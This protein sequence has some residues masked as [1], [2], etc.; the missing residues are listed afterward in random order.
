MRRLSG[1]VRSSPAL[2]VLLVIALLVPSGSVRGAQPVVDGIISPQEYAS[3]SVLADGLY[4]LSWTVSG[5]TV[6]FGIQ[7]T[8]TGWVALGL[9]PEQMMQGADMVFGWVSGGKA[10]VLDQY[11]T[12]TFGPHPDDTTLGGRMD[13][14]SSVG[15]EQQG[16]TT[17][18]YSRKRVTG[19]AYDKPVP[20]SG[21]LK[22]IW[23]FGNA[24]TISPH[25]RRGTAT[26]RVVSTQPAPIILKFT[27]GSKAMTRDGKPV[28]IDVAPV[29][30]NS[31]TLLP[32]RWL[33]D[34]L[35]AALAYDAA[36]RQVTI[37]RGSLTIVLT[38][39]S[40]KAL[41]NGT[42]MPIDPSNPKVVP[43]IIASRTMLP[44]RFVAEQLGC[45][46]TYDAATR[47]VTVVA[48]GS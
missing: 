4:T 24:D 41:V 32:I 8:T 19:D 42:S 29:I 11:A 5:D 45:S 46:I 13:I 31:R 10:T 23:A 44:V 12:G 20:A 48:A 2:I 47:I 22:I 30:Q 17:I 1:E 27:I 18:E 40:S 38:I 14:L 6:W 7:A 39:G 35:G 28:T 43:V 37:S 15:T 3:S 16:T 26:I 36:K 9:D 34:P 33:S 21:N 25:A